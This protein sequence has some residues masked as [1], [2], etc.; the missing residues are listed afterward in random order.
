MNIFKLVGFHFYSPQ[1]YVRKKNRKNRFFSVVL[2]MFGMLSRQQH[3]WQAGF[4]KTPQIWHP[5]I[6]HI[7][8]IL[9]KHSILNNQDSRLNEFLWLFAIGCNNT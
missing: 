6:V 7:G 9:T 1:I 2:R 8:L 4:S 5:P 3:H